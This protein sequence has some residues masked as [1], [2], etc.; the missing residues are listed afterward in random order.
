MSRLANPYIDDRT[1]LHPAD[2]AAAILIAPD[3][4]YVLQQ[5]DDKNGIFFPGHWGCFGGAVDATDSNAEAC[6]IRELEEEPRTC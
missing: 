4:R 5:R 6:L 2:A 3:E 1:I